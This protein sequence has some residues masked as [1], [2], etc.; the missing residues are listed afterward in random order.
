MRMNWDF[1]FLSIADDVLERSTCLRA[2]WG[3]VLVDREHAIISTGYNGAPPHTVN[4][5]D[6]G[7][8]CRQELSVPSGERVELCV[9]IHAE[10]NALLSAGRLAKGAD[11]YLVGRSVATQHEP[12]VADGIPCILCAKLLV[13]AGVRRIFY[14]V[15]DKFEGSFIDGA[16][17]ITPTDAFYLQARKLGLHI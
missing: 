4:C 5:I 7:K 11:M 14:P 8:C 6:T 13:R 17:S 16:E 2:Q 9:A 15:P 10:Q 3:A 1:Y 12:I